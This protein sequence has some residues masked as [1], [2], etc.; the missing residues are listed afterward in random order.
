M[1]VV[2]LTLTR[3][4]Q[5]RMAFRYLWYE[6][7]RIGLQPD[8]PKVNATA[9]ESAFKFRSLRGN[10]V[11]DLKRWQRFINGVITGEGDFTLSQQQAFMMVEHLFF[12][13]CKRKRRGHLSNRNLENV[14]AAIGVDPEEFR[15]LVVEA[16]DPSHLWRS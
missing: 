7:N 10:P 16:S 12:L 1:P 2:E 3:E 5:F 13:Q 4:S 14:A 8:C 9:I 15:A 6:A 11:G